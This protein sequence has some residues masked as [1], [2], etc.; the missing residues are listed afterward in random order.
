MF[1]WTF[2][3]ESWCLK[4]KDRPVINTN[5]IILTFHCSLCELVILL[6]QTCNKGKSLTSTYTEPS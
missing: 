5:A 2:I 1:K 4:F 3:L 6:K